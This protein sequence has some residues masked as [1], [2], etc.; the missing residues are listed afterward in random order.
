M[1]LFLDECLSPQIAL[2]LNAEGRHYVIHP[3]NN[4]GLG[5]PDHKVLERCIDEDLIIVTQNACDFR[6]LAAREEIH[7][8][9][10]M[11]P[12]VGRARAE[13]LIRRA[14]A[15]VEML[16]DPAVIMVNKVL[17]IDSVGG[18]VLYDLPVAPL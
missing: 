12:C 5:D 11:L 15:H 9:M 13:G 8:G 1:R 4:G 7:P 16:G 10:I 3:R 14:I 2:E 6:A 17:E 18:I